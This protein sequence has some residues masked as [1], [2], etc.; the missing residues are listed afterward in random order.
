MFRGSPFCS[1]AASL[2]EKLVSV[3]FSM[4]KNELTP[5]SS[6]TNNLDTLQIHPQ[7]LNTMCTHTRM[8]KVQPLQPPQSPQMDQSGIR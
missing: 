4:S 5:I 1:S 2:G 7:L 8:K 3:H 6:L